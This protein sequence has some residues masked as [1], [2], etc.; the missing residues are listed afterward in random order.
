MSCSCYYGEETAE[1]IMY[2]NFLISWATVSFSICFV[3][4]FNSVLAGQTAESDTQRKM[5]CF[6]ALVWGSAANCTKTPSDAALGV[7]YWVTA[8]LER[9]EFCYWFPG[10]ARQWQCEVFLVGGINKELELNH[11]RRGGGGRSGGNR[12]RK[13]HVMHESHG[14]NSEQISI[15]PPLNYQ[16]SRIV[17]HM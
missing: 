15:P 7:A 10:V 14:N 12:R 8:L 3:K 2:C 17:E 5:P 1:Y 13:I 9:R 11:S 6:S 16:C 4:L